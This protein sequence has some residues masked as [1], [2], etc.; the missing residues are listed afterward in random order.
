MQEVYNMVEIKGH[1]EDTWWIIK[2][3][4]DSIIHYGLTPLGMTTQSGLD[5]KEEFT[6]ELTWANQ[7]LKR[8]NITGDTSNNIILSG[9]TWI[10]V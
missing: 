3:I 6:D 8:Y 10:N 7:L 4:D 1:T 9:G 5:T 2:K